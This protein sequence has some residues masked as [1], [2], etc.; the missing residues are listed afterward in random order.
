M[1][2]SVLPFNFSVRLPRVAVNEGDAWHQ[3]SIALVVRYVHDIK[4]W[5]YSKVSNLYWLLHE[6]I[7][8][9][10]RKGMGMYTKRKDGRSHRIIHVQITHARPRFWFLKIVTLRKIT[11][12]VFLLLQFFLSYTT[13]SNV[14]KRFCLLWI[15]Q[16]QIT[17]PSQN[18]LLQRKKGRLLFTENISS[19]LFEF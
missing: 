17:L 16:V 13:V 19:E 11:L 2:A 10:M 15:F 7:V 14:F 3:S 18:Q 6:N 4:V 8:L 1:V 9:I 5:L 12:N